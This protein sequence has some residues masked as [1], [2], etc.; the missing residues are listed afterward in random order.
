MRLFGVKF[1]RLSVELL[2][3]V[4]FISIFPH[5]VIVK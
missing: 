1:S 4:F 5:S 3:L 2:D